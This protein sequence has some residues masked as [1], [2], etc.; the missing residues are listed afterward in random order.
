MM[1]LVEVVARHVVERLAQIPD[2]MGCEGPVVFGELPGILP[3][4]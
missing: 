4:Q 1:V 2:V 3:L